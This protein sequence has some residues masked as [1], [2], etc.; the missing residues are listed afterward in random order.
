MNQDRRCG[1]R[2]AVRAAIFAL[3]LA[4]VGTAAFAQSGAAGTPLSAEEIRACLCLE[5]AI[6]DLRRETDMQQSLRDERVTELNQV[7]Q[8]IEQRRVTMDGSD[9]A[10]VQEMQHLVARQQMLRDLLH[11][12]VGDAYRDRIKELN[13][14]V[15]LYNEQCT[16][17]P[18]FKIEVERA[19]ENLQCPVQ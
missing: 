19:K 9:P 3:G 2:V 16:T 14:R 5:Q 11:S 7:D 15:A 13:S 17:R 8:E 6:T 12:E 1:L 10:A 4:P 18:M